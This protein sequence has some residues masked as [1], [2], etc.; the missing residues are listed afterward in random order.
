MY[1]YLLNNL[2]LIRPFLEPFDNL[3]PFH[4]YVL[5]LWYR[6]IGAIYNGDRLEIEIDNDN[7]FVELDSWLMNKGFRY[8]PRDSNDNNNENTDKDKD[9]ANKATKSK[10]TITKDTKLPSDEEI[11]NIIESKLPRPEDLQRLD[12]IREF[13]DEI[14]NLSSRMDALSLSQPYMPDSAVERVQTIY[15]IN[16]KIY[17]ENKKKELLVD[18]LKSNNNPN[19]MYV[20]LSI[21]PDINNVIIHPARDKQKSRTQTIILN[22]KKKK[23]KERIEKI[24]NGLS[25]DMGS[26]GLPLGGNSTNTENNDL[27]NTLFHDLNNTE[28]NNDDNNDDD[29]EIHDEPMD[30]E[31][32]YHYN[33]DDFPD[34]DDNEEEINN[35]VIANF[36]NENDIL[37]EK[38]R[39]EYELFPEYFEA[40]KDSIIF[41]N[42]HPPKI[43]K[44]TIKQLIRENPSNSYRAEYFYTKYYNTPDSKFVTDTIAAYFTKYIGNEFYLDQLVNMDLLAKLGNYNSL[45]LRQQEW[46][47]NPIKGAWEDFKYPFTYMWQQLVDF[48]KM[49]VSFSFKNLLSADFLVRSSLQVLTLA[50]IQFNPFV[51]TGIR[52]TS[53]ILNIAMPIT[54]IYNYYQ[55][56]IPIKNMMVRELSRYSIEKLFSMYIPSPHYGYKMNKKKW[57]IVETIQDRI[58]Y[59]IQD[60]TGARDLYRDNVNLFPNVPNLNIHRPLDYHNFI[61]FPDDYL[62]PR[63]WI[64][65]E[66]FARNPLY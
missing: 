11:F 66:D 59:W 49:V 31:E 30:E 24:E 34:D 51:E 50:G 55:N 29:I 18:E 42:L 39:K 43:N 5:Q 13:N 28:I 65:I 19:N 60:R 10:L 62:R 16:K 9:N 14:E 2:D 47:P 37:Y 17:S 45:Q 44:T 61:V 52:F 58:R 33:K 26:G 3:N 12:R 57:K 4:E 53:Q 38:F 25:H 15:I 32:D 6:Y 40:N 7:P 22:K 21:N 63:P 35:D 27:N 54:R 23:R 56:K 1:R 20:N 46:K 48:S 41:R 8:I 36:T 64:Q